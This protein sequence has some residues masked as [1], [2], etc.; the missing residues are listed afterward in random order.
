MFKY[1]YQQLG[2][3]EIRLLLLMPGELADEIH[4]S[5]R[6]ARLL[7]DAPNTNDNVSDDIDLEVKSDKVRSSWQL[8]SVHNAWGDDDDSDED[9]EDYCC[10]DNDAASTDSE[11]MSIDTDNEM[12]DS[13]ED[14]D[15]DGY[16]ALSYVWGSPINPKTIFINA[17]GSEKAMHEVTQNLY[18]A[19]IHLRLTDKPRVL[20]I[21][22]V[23]INQD[24]MIEK[25]RQV[26]LMGKIY[27]L[28]RSVAI[29]LG[30]EENDSAFALKIVEELGQY[31]P[32]ATDELLRTVKYGERELRAIYSLFARPWFER[33]WIRQEIFLATSATIQCGYDTLIWATLKAAA[34]QIVGYPWKGSSLG[35]SQ[36]MFVSKWRRLQYLVRELCDSTH[37][38][39][40]YATLRCSLQDV[41]WTDPKDT[42]YAMFFLLHDDDRKL[43][44]EPD[45]TADVYTIFEN[46]AVRV[47]ERQQSLEILGTCELNPLH[48][49]IQSGLPSWVPDWASHLKA[50]RPWRTE[51]SASAWIFPQT[52]I[53]L[54]VLRSAGVAVATVSEVMY[55]HP[56][57]NTVDLE[58]LIDTIRAIRPPVPLE[59]LYA[60]GR[61][62]LET[63]A[64]VLTDD[65]RP[66][67]PVDYTKFNLQH[68][69]AALYTIWSWPSVP[70]IDWE[71]LPD[72]TEVPVK[73]RI[74]KNIRYFL[75]VFADCSIGRCFIRTNKV[76]V[77]CSP[78][79]TQP[80]DVIAV[81]LGSLLPLVLREVPIPGSH[82]SAA[83][84]QWQVVGPCRIPGIMNGE[85]IY[86]HL[87]NHYQPVSSRDPSFRSGMRFQM[88]DE[89]DGS[90][91]G[92]P[93]EILS[94]MG[95]QYLEY[96]QKSQQLLVAPEALRNA[97]V[98]LQ[99]FHI[100]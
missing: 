10:D 48:S 91:R 72:A 79:A 51:W 81:L 32:L 84:H 24:D 93:A 83:K 17:I 97:G 74:D 73:G 47:I 68:A 44:I 66:V 7:D 63:Y 76:Y 4:V 53:H 89:R 28:A 77:G 69:E 25:G 20:W 78:V 94:E 95:I 14:N 29:W 50:L 18:V 52:D 34:Q 98:E 15:I 57:E 22:A 39:E 55:L 65:P 88:H 40:S 58:I 33:L 2:H 87:P 9:D 6:T 19:L 67:Y 27:G 43:G 8:G 82:N 13:Q 71:R 80:G 70:L 62:V 64:Y 12:A 60:S 35:S 31:E 41:K 16:E 99:D 96:C 86:R 30:P 21:D 54:G 42:I 37:E 85:V 3:D 56:D 49:N 36:S 11:A 100:I 1:Q 5:L 90:L 26:A 92:N 45:Y 61:T 75:N 59:S 38:S 23:C 46:V